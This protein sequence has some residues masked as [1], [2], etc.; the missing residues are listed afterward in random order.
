[1]RMFNE[2]NA[3]LCILNLKIQKKMNHLMKSNESNII[4]NVYSEKFRSSTAAKYFIPF[5]V[6]L[7]CVFYDFGIFVLFA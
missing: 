4:R 7:F 1:M 2:A 6:I 5:K 3:I